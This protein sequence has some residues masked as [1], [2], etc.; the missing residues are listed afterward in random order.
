MCRRRSLRRD[1]S[2]REGNEGDNRAE[3]AAR[4]YRELIDEQ[5]FVKGDPRAGRKPGSK[6]R[7]TNTFLNDVLDEWEKGGK[8]ALRI[9]RIENPDRFC[10]MVASL[11]P[12]ELM[13]APA[14]SELDDAELDDMISRLREQLAQHAPLL[15]EAEAND[16]N[17]VAVPAER[18]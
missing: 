15:I 8:D 3:K 1:R 12:R 5:P 16:G 9:F 13:L 2:R 4:E 10:V 6:V 7:L 14:A 11:V 17:G 18:E